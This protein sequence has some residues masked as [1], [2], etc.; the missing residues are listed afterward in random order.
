M[1]SGASPVSVGAFQVTSI[2]VGL[3]RVATGFV[4][5]PGSPYANLNVFTLLVRI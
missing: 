3:V 1:S 2:S 4:G 5:T